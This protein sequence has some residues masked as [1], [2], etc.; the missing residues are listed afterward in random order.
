V[1]FS[2]IGSI[3][4]DVAFSPTLYAA[5]ICRVKPKPLSKSKES[6]TMLKHGA[7]NAAAL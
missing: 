3:P 6:L 2:A 4:D 5:R 1:N 7:L